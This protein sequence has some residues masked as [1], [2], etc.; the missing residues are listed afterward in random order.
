MN[1]EILMKIH[2]ILLFIRQGQTKTSGKSELRHPGPGGRPL[3]PGGRGHERQALGDGRGH[4]GSRGG[5]HGLQDG[6]SVTRI[7]IKCDVKN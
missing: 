2:L 3:V 5:L 6:Q 4:P 1:I 7:K